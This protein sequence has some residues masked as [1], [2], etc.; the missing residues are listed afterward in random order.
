MNLLSLLR[1]LGFF[2]KKK[3]ALP[4]VSRAEAQCTLNQYASQVLARQMQATTVPV[5]N[6]FTDPY[7]VVRSRMA[8]RGKEIARLRRAKKRHRH[9]VALQEEDRNFLLRREVKIAEDSRNALYLH[10]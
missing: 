7:G 4:R 6:E 10:G 8:V 5:L 1:N 2:R 3:E 9:L